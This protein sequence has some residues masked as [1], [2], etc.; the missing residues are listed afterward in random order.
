MENIAPEA[1][2]KLIGITFVIIAGL[3]VL[4]SYLRKRKNNEEEIE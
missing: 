3:I 2:G 4:R 1:L